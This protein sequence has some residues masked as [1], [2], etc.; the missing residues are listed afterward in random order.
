TWNPIKALPG[1]IGELASLKELDIMITKV[2]ALPASIGKLANLRKLRIPDTITTVPDGFFT[3]ALDHFDGARELRDRL[4]LPALAPHA[5]SVHHPVAGATVLPPRA[6]APRRSRAT[7]R[8]SHS[9]RARSPAAA[10][11]AADQV[12]SPRARDRRSRSRSRAA[13]RGIDRDI[14]GALDRGQLR[15]VA[16][17]DRQP[18]IARVPRHR[19][20]MH[21][22]SG[23]AREPVAS[24]RA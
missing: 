17:L 8:A 1:R 2:R 24:R 21:I 7:A 13:P 5:R 16:A 20:A 19:G 11:R 3:L 10:A 9:L 12:A 4:T 14:E 22:A 15:D 6:V 18:A 23:R